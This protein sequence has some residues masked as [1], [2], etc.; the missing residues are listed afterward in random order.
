MQV[1]A[2][3]GIPNAKHQG[4][5]HSPLVWAS[6]PEENKL[7]LKYLCFLLHHMSLDSQAVISVL[8]A[9]PEA[10]RTN[11]SSR[12]DRHSL[13]Q[14]ANSCSAPTIIFRS[15]RFLK[16]FLDLFPAF[17]ADQLNHLIIGHS[18]GE[19]PKSSPS[20]LLLRAPVSQRDFIAEQT[21]RTYY[22]NEKCSRQERLA[23]YEECP[24][25]PAVVDFFSSIDSLLGA[26]KRTLP[27]Q[28][29]Y[30]GVDKMCKKYKQDMASGIAYMSLSTTMTLP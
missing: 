12:P 6:L 10:L 18:G 3:Y 22:S 8:Y 16:C 19:L 21:T 15:S 2:G 30:S 13:N 29:F 25:P 20:E 14:K 9:K 26:A 27:P 5:S 24:R 1:I 11:S 23:N 7:F 28:T 4:F 17:M